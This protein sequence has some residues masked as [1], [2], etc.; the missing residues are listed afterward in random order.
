MYCGLLR[1]FHTNPPTPMH[2][3]AIKPITQTPATVTIRTL[4]EYRLFFLDLGFDFA[5]G[6]AFAAA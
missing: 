3:T 2:R 6:F 4:R 5:F 1:R